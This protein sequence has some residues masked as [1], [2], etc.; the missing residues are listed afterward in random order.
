MSK[1]TVLPPKKEKKDLDNG[2]SSAPRSLR[3]RRRAGGRRLQ[4]KRHPAA[5]GVD[6]DEGGQA[7]HDLEQRGPEHQ[8]SLELGSE[9]E[10]RH[11]LEHQHGSIV[12]IHLIM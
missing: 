3:L 7:A 8:R 5:D 11:S 10:R 6:L 1:K 9:P 12:A 4:Q 2:I